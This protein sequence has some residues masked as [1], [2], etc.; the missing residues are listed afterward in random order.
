MDDTAADT[1]ACYD[2]AGSQNVVH[3]SENGLEQLTNFI[4]ACDVFDESFG[5]KL[6]SKL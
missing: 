1:D 2:A 4:N 5:D 6:I 3:A